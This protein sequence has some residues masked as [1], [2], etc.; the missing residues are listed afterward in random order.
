MPDYAAGNEALSAGSDFGGFRIDGVLGR[1][2]MGVVYRANDTR[3]QRPIALKVVASHLAADET[4]RERFVAE[5]RAAAMVEHPAIVAI[6]AAGEH[7]GIP[8]IAMKL[9]EGKELSDVLEHAGRLAPQDALR[10]LTPIASALDA[11]ATAGIVHRDVKPSNILVPTDGSGAV[12]V[13]FG[14]GRIAGSSRNTQSGSWLGTPNYVAPEQV[15]GGEIDG[16]ADQYALTCVLFELLAGEPPFVRDQDMQTL[17]AHVNEDPPAAPPGSDALDG[18]IRRG[19]AKAPADRF[20][21]SSAMIEAATLALGLAPVP[22]PV[23]SS[24]TG[25]VIADAPAKVLPKPPANASSRRPL[26]LLVAAVVIVAIAAVA[27]FALGGSGSSGDTAMEETSS[28]GTTTAGAAS[29]STS[30]SA[31]A[32]RSFDGAVLQ[33]AKWRTYSKAPNA[34]LASKFNAC[35]S[36]DPAPQAIRSCIAPV[37]SRPEYDRIVNWFD[38]PL[39]DELSAAYASG[40]DDAAFEQRNATCYERS[41]RAIEVGKGRAALAE[42]LYAALSSGNTAQAATVNQRISSEK[43][44][45]DGAWDLFIEACGLPTRFESS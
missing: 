24:R 9:I 30:N 10:I 26:L 7:D 23:R 43:T 32:Q 28:S 15:Q 5:A 16:R 36:A 41:N 34:R 17:W 45:F 19:M 2:A 38:T 18:V 31:A 21:S 8:F 4:F 1:G 37:A 25:T 13:D 40:A 6:Y 42:D 22:A 12:L 39:A 33:I 29:G 27:F 3:L 14:I 44:A 20:D 11:A 35:Q